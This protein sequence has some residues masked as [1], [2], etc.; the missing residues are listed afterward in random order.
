MGLEEI[1]TEKELVELLQID[2]ATMYKLRQKGMPFTRLN[3]VRRVYLVTEVLEWIKDNQIRHSDDTSL[4]DCLPDG[5]AGARQAGK[6]RSED[7]IE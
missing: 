4:P 2:E 7:K 5:K 1:I 6:R 3:R